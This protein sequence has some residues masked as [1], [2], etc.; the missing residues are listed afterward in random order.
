M[1]K[2]K[3]AIE[4]TAQNNGRLPNLVKP[5]IVNK[6]NRNSDPVVFYT[7]HL[8]LA[9]CWKLDL[10]LKSRGLKL[11]HDKNQKKHGDLKSLVPVLG[12]R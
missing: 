1:L 7:M 4:A 3:Q 5:A 2:E 12:I 8:A 11:A 6:H 9:F 10:T